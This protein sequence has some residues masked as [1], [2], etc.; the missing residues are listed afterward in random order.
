MHT[1]KVGSKCICCRFLWW[2]LCHQQDPSKTFFKISLVS[3]LRIQPGAGS[4]LPTPPST[5]LTM[6]KVKKLQPAYKELSQIAVNNLVKQTQN[7]CV[8]IYLC[9][10]HGLLQMQHTYMLRTLFCSYYVSS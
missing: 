8:D 10:M 3:G 6:K 5:I 1:G 7:S 4:I 2:H 9:P